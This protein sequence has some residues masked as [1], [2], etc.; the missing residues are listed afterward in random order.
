VIDSFLSPQEFL[1]LGM[2]Q[3]RRFFAAQPALA[4]ASVNDGN[5]GK[6]CEGQA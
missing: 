6:G 4:L 2:I 3:V 1:F 5:R